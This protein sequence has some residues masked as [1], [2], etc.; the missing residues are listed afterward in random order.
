MIKKLMGG[1]NMETTT[2]EKQKRQ[3]AKLFAVICNNE[4]FH[5]TLECKNEKE[6]NEQYHKLDDG[7]F[8][9]S[10][11]KGHSLDFKMTEYISIK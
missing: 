9:V 10:V 7:C 11:V 4:G 1:D 6:L 5:S 8:I 3:A 2:I